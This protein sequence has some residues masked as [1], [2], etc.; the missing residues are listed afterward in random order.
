M[1]T[2]ESSKTLFQQ[3]EIRTDIKTIDLVYYTSVC[4]E[5]NNKKKLP[6]QTKSKFNSNKPYSQRTDSTNHTNNNTGVNST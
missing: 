1:S 6:S 4:F 5:K 3:I 2:H